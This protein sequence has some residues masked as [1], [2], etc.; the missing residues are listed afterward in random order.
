MSGEME[1]T[2]TIAAIAT[3]PGTG[4]IA[5]VRMSGARAAEI[6]QTCTG[7]VL[8]PRRA[9][10]VRLRNAAGQVVDDAVATYFAAPASYTGEDVVEVS[11]HGGMLVTRR[12]LECLLAAGARPA[13]PGEFSRRAFEN[14][15]M[16][17]TQAEAVMDVIAAGSDLALRAAHNQLHG[18][19][20]KRVA[21]AVD[22]LIS[23]A[24]HV[25]AYIDFPEEDIAPDT[26]QELVAAIDGVLAEL[27]ALLATA[28]EGRL[29]REGVR[30]AIVG[31]P[32]VGKSSLLNMLLGY[33]RAI[34]SD[35]AGTTRDT[36]EESVTL[37][38][39]RLRLIDTAGLHES[40][41]AIEQAGMER[42]RR[43]GAEA[44]LVLEVADATLP[45]ARPELEL[46]GAQHL[47][48]LNKCDLPEHAA[49]QG[50]SAHRLSCRTGQGVQ[51]L[52]AAIGQLFLHD[53]AEADSLAAINTRHR[54]ALQQAVD[55]LAVAQRSLLAAESPELT[56]VEL[57]AALDALGS[58]SGRVDTEDI[59]TRVFA[60]F[61]L[62]K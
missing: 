43:A 32:N 21:A 37:G 58:I 13:E 55:F 19:I 14:G 4:A 39:L 35:T 5:V 41:D 9:A 7:R 6:L 54:Y 11:C 56:D 61:C 60:T 8:K 22:K 15:K 40:A 18:A 59:L 50:V 10:L 36:I 24:A 17:L 25:E 47:L 3:P 42:S 46:T 51:E 20:S 53:H 57:R 44:D 34:V 52:A 49:W 23:V 1:Y 33:E 38:G 29:L 48:L 28:D 12:V 26:T 62:G 16:D 45:P 30:T 2:D 27:H 31:P